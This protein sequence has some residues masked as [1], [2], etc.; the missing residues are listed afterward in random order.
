M[1]ETYI[2]DTCV[3]IQTILDAHKAKDVITAEIN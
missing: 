2:I 3:F 1:S